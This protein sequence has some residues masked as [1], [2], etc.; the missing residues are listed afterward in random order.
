MSEKIEHVRDIGGG[1]LRVGQTNVPLESVI[2]SFD[3]GESAEEMCRQY[4]SLTLRDAY[5]AISWMLD[6]PED[7]KA[8]IQRQR[9]LWDELKK[10]NEMIP[11]ELRQRIL[12]GRKVALP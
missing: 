2:A 9:A 6:H 12:G 8:Y 7:T 3:R 1:D 4:R 5:G 11:A 10:N